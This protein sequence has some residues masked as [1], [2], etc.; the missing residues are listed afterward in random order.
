[1][2][3]IAEKLNKLRK[4]DKDFEV[5]GANS[6]K[7]KMNPVLTEAEIKAYEERNNLTLPEDYR[8]FL[9]NIGNGGAGPQY[10]L[11]ELSDPEN[12]DDYP[13][14]YGQMFSVVQN[15]EDAEED[16]EDDDNEPL[17]SVRE[18][19]VYEKSQQ[20]TVNICT[21][22]CGME[23]MIVL[24]G[25][26]KGAVWFTDFGN[27]SGLFPI[28]SKINNGTSMTFAEWYE[29]WLDA[30]LAGKSFQASDLINGDDLTQIEVTEEEIEIYREGNE[31]EDDEDQDEDD[32]DEDEDETGNN[33][34]KLLEISNIK[35]YIGSY[36]QLGGAQMTTGK[37]E[38]GLQTYAEAIA[39]ADF[40][41]AYL[42]YCYVCNL[43]N[44]VEFL[45]GKEAQRCIDMIISEGRKL[46]QMMPEKPFTQAHVAVLEDMHRLGGNHFAWYSYERGEN[47]PEAL[48][49][50]EIAVQYINGNSFYYFIYDTHV[51]ILLALKRN[52]EAY[53]IVDKILK[54]FPDFGDFQDLKKDKDFVKWQ[55]QGS[56]KPA[57]I[58][59]P[60]PTTVSAANQAFDHTIGN[61]WDDVLKKEFEADYFQKLQ[62]FL[63]DEYA[64]KT[65]YPAK[66]N[67]FNTL[68]FTAPDKVRVVILGQD[69]Y[70]NE[71]QAH[72]FALSV[73]PGITP[74]PSLKNM[75]KELESDLGIPQSKSGH[76]IKW[77]EQGVLLLN[78]V[79][80]V[81]AGKSNSH[82]KK[83]W[84][85]FTDAVFA[86]LGASEQPIV[87]MLW[88]K[89]AQTKE[90]FITGK[91]HCIIK[92][93]HPSPLSASTG[94]FGS[95]P[96]SQANAFL[97][98]KGLPE[99][100]WRV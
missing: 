24:K 43:R 56:S 59:S 89:P 69:P 35:G 45:K 84:E 81:E 32:E 9:A 68:K 8:W 19:I 15:E 66:E 29:A 14:V 92:S 39:R 74:P 16:A 23:I 46:L 60:K 75:Y 6:H 78:T 49:A 71:G 5:F 38:E 94:F 33:K 62:D 100:D 82:A 57:A 98:E 30:A 99:I 44:V 47:L 95:K 42:Q 34:N 1:M 48:K 54:E 55:K 61:D 26:E 37:F 58:S 25:K 63:A 10:G 18:D 31:D 65:I 50:I 73:L 80:T 86:Y 12:D 7:Y 52:E 90:K 36:T 53:V 77:A 3:R 72:G 20:G 4:Q 83:G 27:E 79:L 64:T 88:G 28:E 41:R 97:K 70:I 17:Y 91:N 85:K 96:Y 93:P 51:R 2:Q 87:F 22:G 13:F 21:E 76:L 11:Y 40:D 67:I